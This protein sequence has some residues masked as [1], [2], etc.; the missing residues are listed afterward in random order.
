MTAWQDHDS[1]IDA[2]L[3]GEFVVTLVVRWDRHDGASAVLDQ[4]VVRYPNGNF[5]VIERIDG[6]AARKEALLLR[7]TERTSVAKDALFSYECVQL[8]EQFRIATNQLRNNRMLGSELDRSCSKDRVDTSGENRDLLARLGDLEVNLRSLAAADPV[9]LHSAHFLRPAFE[10][11]Q[12]AKQFIRVAGDTQEPLLQITLLYGSF[13]V[14]PAAA[15]HDLLVCQNGRALRTPVHLALAAVRQSALVELQEEPLIPAV[16]VGQTRR[17]LGLPI[18]GEAEPLHLPL[19]IGDVIQR[20]FT[21]RGVV[22]E[23]S[24][25]SGQA[26]GVPPHWMKY[27]VA[28]HPHVARERVADGVIAH[29]SHMQRAR[30]IR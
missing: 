11:V 27:V 18:I 9:A 6:I 29:V 8:C 25:L 23:R 17:N 14:S 2:V 28:F 7:F 24:I 15:V 22:L 4:D 20:P 1:D 3:L 5:L 19:H 12:V 13:F 21:R 16:V 26:E 30:R 10:F